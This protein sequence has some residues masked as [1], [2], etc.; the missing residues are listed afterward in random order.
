MSQDEADTS[1]NEKEENENKR[2]ED[3]EVSEQASKK[4][5]QEKRKPQK[6]QLLRLQATITDTAEEVGLDP[7]DLH[8]VALLVVHDALGN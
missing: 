1:Q 3:S 2:D 4:K 5:K 8:R 7:K 6:A